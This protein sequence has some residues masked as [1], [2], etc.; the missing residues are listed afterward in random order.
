MPKTTE[1]LAEL[2]DRYFKLAEKFAK[3]AGDTGIG[4]GT[5]HTAVKSAG[6]CMRTALRLRAQRL[7]EEREANTRY[8][9]PQ[10]NHGTAK[11]P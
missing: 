6:K 7:D 11:Q 9:N 10:K 5:T 3:Y 2:E 4:Y 1:E 8:P